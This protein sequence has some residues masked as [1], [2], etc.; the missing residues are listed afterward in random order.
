MLCC[1][2]EFL[3]QFTQA[4]YAAI[5]NKPEKMIFIP[6]FSFFLFFVLTTDL[7]T[8][9]EKILL[10]AEIILLLDIY[11]IYIFSISSLRT[12]KGIINYCGC[13]LSEYWVV[14]IGD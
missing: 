11:N 14:G 1:A 8:R 5:S 13:E 10:H 2:T 6:F 9:G 3:I 4:F 12:G 7:N